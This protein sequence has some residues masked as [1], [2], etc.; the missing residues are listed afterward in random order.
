MKSLQHILTTVLVA[1]LMFFFITPA[2]LSVVTPGNAS[3]IL[4]TAQAQDDKPYRFLAPIG[5]LGEEADGGGR[6]IDVSSE[7]SFPDYIKTMIL[8]VIGFAILAAVVIIIASGFQY[9]T[10]TSQSGVSK[11]K[12]QMTNAILG[13]VL[14]LSAVMILQTINPDLIEL[15]SVDTVTTSGSSLVINEGWSDWEYGGEAFGEDSKERGDKHCFYIQGDFTISWF[16]GLGGDENKYICFDSETGCEDGL[17]EARDKDEDDGGW[18][19]SSQCRYYYESTGILVNNDGDEKTKLTGIGTSAN[20]AIEN[21]ELHAF[22]KATQAP[23]IDECVSEQSG[24]YSLDSNKCTALCGDA[25]QESFTPPDHWVEGDTKWCYDDPTSSDCKTKKLLCE[26]SFG[27]GC[28]PHPTAIYNKL[29][30]RVNAS[31]TNCT[32]LSTGEYNTS[33]SVT[34]SPE[35]SIYAESF[36]RIDSDLSELIELTAAGAPGVNFHVSESF[37]PLG[38]RNKACYYDGT[39]VSTQAID[40]VGSP[41]ANN[42]LSPAHFDAVSIFITM[43]EQVGLEV[44]YRV[45]SDDLRDFLVN[46]DSGAIEDQ[47]V[48]KIPGLDE[49]YFNV[50]HQ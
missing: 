2:L 26:N 32:W 24:G 27:G 49:P 22:N 20:A 29:N 28:Y 43:A 8:I 5:G 4:P 36:C 48:K 45:G 37:P 35:S 3:E 10:S 11:A 46:H 6:E 47:N 34:C 42:N 31:C 41:Y 13:L 19:E 12:E 18:I 30:D 40:D 17:Q 44:E 50:E 33:S 16:F 25:E 39:C 9:M 7:D 23:V 1:S 38:R 21:C 15:S 14:A